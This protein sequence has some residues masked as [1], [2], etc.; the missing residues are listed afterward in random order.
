MSDDPQ[1]R[2]A[3]IPPDRQLSPRL[4]IKEPEYCSISE[5]GRILDQPE[6]TLRAWRNRFR[7]YIISKEDGDGNTV[8]LLKRLRQIQYMTNE[9]AKGPPRRSLGEV[10]RELARMFPV[11]AT[12]AG[13]VVE[14]APDLEAPHDV[15]GPA[16]EPA[17][18]SALD[19]D[20]VAALAL[21]PDAISANTEAIGKLAARFDAAALG[22]GPDDE[23]LLIIS[24]VKAATG[25]LAEALP[26]LARSVEAQEKRLEQAEAQAERSAAFEQ[27][28]LAFLKEQREREEAGVRVVTLTWSERRWLRWLNPSFT[29]RTVFKCWR[30]SLDPIRVR[31]LPPGDPPAD[32]PSP[33]AQAPQLAGSREGA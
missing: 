8:Y 33:E 11:E 18:A 32:P 6:S 2:V 29:V 7:P 15:R 1:E 30:A 16:V 28:I 14:P 13:I 31:E 24:E 9:W 21:L 5:A 17:A 10:G 4:D 3:T 22:R 19:P 25:A 23:L 26:L 27:R 12:A 20:T